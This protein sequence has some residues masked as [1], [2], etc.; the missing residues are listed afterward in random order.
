[1]PMLALQCTDGHTGE[2]FLHTIQDLGAQTRLCPECGH[3]L[4]PALSVGRGLTFFEEG[5]PFLMQH[6]VPTPILITSHAQHKRVMR[7]YG[8]E[9][10]YRWTQGPLGGR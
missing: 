10:A 6:G 7:Q 3:S 4:A 5:R 8:L 2:Q 9:P 1:M